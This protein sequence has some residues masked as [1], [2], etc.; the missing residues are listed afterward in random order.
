MSRLPAWYPDLQPAKGMIESQMTDLGQG[1][2]QPCARRE[3]SVILD[4]SMARASESLYYRNGLRIVE[5]KCP[6]SCSNRSMPLPAR[7]PPA[8]PSLP[9][10][11]LYCLRF[12]PPIH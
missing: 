2:R 1:G 5:N 4:R 6:E 11:C 10:L 7:E 8:R 12:P 3:S 9:K